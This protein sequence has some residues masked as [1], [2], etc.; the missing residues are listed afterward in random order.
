MVSHRRLLVVIA[1][2]LA[3]GVALAASTTKQQRQHFLDARAALEKGD[4]AR[5]DKLSGQL[6]DYPLYP[7]LLYWQMMRA[8]SLD[9]ERVRGFLSRYG[10][11][12]FTQPLREQWLAQLA[13]QERWDEYLTDYRPSKKSE[14]RCHYHYAQLQGG[15]EISAWAGAHT[16]WLSGSRQDSACNRLFDAWAKAGGLTAKLRRERL[17][18]ALQAGNMD[19]AKQLAAALPEAE[20]RRVALWQQVRNKPDTLASDPTLQKDNT[21]HRELVVYGVTQLARSDANA[22]ADLWQQLAPRYTFSDAQRHAVLNALVLW[23]ALRADPSALDWFK[24]LPVEAREAS[25]RQWAVRVAL[26][27]Q[28]WEEALAILR[29]LPP[30]ERRDEEWQYWTARSLEQN[31]DKELA[32]S[33]Y[34]GIANNRSYYGFLAADHLDVGY[35]LSHQPVAADATTLS[36]LGKIPAVSRAYELLQLDLTREAR[37]EWDY[38]TARMDAAQQL[39]A[40]K[41]ASQWNWHDRAALTLA[42]ADYYDDLEI[43]FPLAFTDTVFKEAKA[44][45]L[46]PAWVLAVARQESVMNPEARSPVGALGLMQLMPAT[47]RKIGQKL[48]SA[49]SDLQQLLTPE[50]NIRFG[51]Y[52]LRELSDQF[53]DHKALATAAYNAGPHRVAKW[54]PPQTTMDADIWVDNIPFNETRTYVRRVLAYSVF[55]DQRLEQPIVRLSDRMPVV[56]Q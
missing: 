17:D 31:G 22:A 15:N 36:E 27:H 52:Y 14:L 21:E 34:Y 41:L 53:G 5:F 2:L 32:R 45:T 46:D 19:L 6:R 48:K 47:G 28:R 38:A 37:Q 23:L 50:T 49:I 10:D 30:S 51:S 54:A 9:S 40:G 35:N 1:L 12:P 3:S 13:D 11:A 42:R 44:N 43:R 39:A 7:Y 20:Q 18:L 29:T 33:L 26:R 25:S 4:T 16:L 56:Q 55:Y 24:Q 8:E